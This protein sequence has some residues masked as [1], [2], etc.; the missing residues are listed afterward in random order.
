MY[1]IKIQNTLQ[2]DMEDSR[3]VHKEKTRPLY[4]RLRKK[5]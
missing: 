5:T 4:S 3:E 2:H 1:R